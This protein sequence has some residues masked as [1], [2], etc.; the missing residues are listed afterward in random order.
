MGKIKARSVYDDTPYWRVRYEI[1]FKMKTPTGVL[2]AKAWWRQIL[3]QGV[4]YKD[5]EGNVQL[6]PNGELVLLNADGTKADPAS[7]HWLEFR[8]WPDATWADLGLNN[9]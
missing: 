8:D 3:D 6:S 5:A 7:P 1:T 4:K 9:T 2:D